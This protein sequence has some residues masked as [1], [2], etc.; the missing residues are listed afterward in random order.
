L[1]EGISKPIISIKDLYSYHSNIVYYS[2]YKY[3]LK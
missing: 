1:R 3:L 2:G